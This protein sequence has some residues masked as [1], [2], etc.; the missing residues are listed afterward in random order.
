[1]IHSCIGYGGDKLNDPVYAHLRFIDDFAMSSIFD[2]NERPAT[3]DT[4]D[5]ELRTLLSH[6]IIL[7]LQNKS[8]DFYE[9]ESVS[10]GPILKDP[11][12]CKFARSLHLHVNLLIGLSR[13]E[14]L[15]PAIRTRQQPTSKL[16]R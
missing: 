12:Y 1:M 7:A 6:S 5:H 10:D 9:F 13:L 11:S 15:V 8:V 3:R 2:R 4:I 14:T 16:I